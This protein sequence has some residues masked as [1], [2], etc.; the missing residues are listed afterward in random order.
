MEKW[1]ESFYT[2][3]SHGRGADD[4]AGWAV[5]DGGQLLELL[6]HALESFSCFGRRSPLLWIL[7]DMGFGN[8]GRSP[9]ELVA[10]VLVMA[11]PFA[12]GTHKI[13]PSSRVIPWC[14]VLLVLRLSW[15]R[16]S[17]AVDCIGW[18]FNWSFLK[19]EATLFLKKFGDGFIK[20]GFNLLVE[21]LTPDELELWSQPMKELTQAACGRLS[22]S[23]RISRLGPAV[24]QFSMDSPQFIGESEDVLISLFEWVRPDEEIIDPGLI[25]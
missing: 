23:H 16:G 15:S 9:M 24:V 1:N 21:Q 11:R 20:G 2:R 19:L 25:T 3:V 22:S 18:P 13:F 8:V 6:H 4:G 7:Y 14:I 17:I 5:D 10:L 12:V